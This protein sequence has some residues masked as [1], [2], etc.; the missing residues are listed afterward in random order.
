VKFLQRNFKCNSENIEIDF[1]SKVRLGVCRNLGGI[2]D[3]MSNI[4]DR[5]LQNVTNDTVELQPLPIVDLLQENLTDVESRHLM[6]LTSDGSA[7]DILF[8]EKILNITEVDVIFGLDFPLDNTDVHI[9][10]NITHIKNCMEHGHPVV[11][12]HLE[13][14][15]ESLYD[16]YISSL[17]F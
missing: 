2:P 12:L 8:Q 6:L 16:M 10:H 7:L 17:N 3:Q 11:L 9:C 15:Y 13:N 4:L 1:Q 14:L 5:F